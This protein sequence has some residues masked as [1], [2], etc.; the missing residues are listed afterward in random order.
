MNRAIYRKQIAA[1]YS[2]PKSTLLLRPQ[3]VISVRCD[4]WSIPDSWW[5]KVA[6]PGLVKLVTD[7]KTDPEGITYA[8]LEHEVGKCPLPPDP[9]VQVD[10][11]GTPNFWNG[12]PQMLYLVQHVLQEVNIALQSTPP[13]FAILSLYR[14]PL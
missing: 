11:P 8:L 14:G 10:T 6:Q 9:D 7:G 5:F 2:L 13:R 3:I 12:P 1:R 4:A